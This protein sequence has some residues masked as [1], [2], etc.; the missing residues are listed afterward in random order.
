MGRICH[1]MIENT[2]QRGQG[3]GGGMQRIR[4]Q[5]RLI[6]TILDRRRAHARSHRNQKEDE[7]MVS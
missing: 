7:T 4:L 3:S 6:C 1:S 2:E 5:K